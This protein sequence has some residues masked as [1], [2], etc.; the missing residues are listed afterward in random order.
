[1]PELNH[2]GRNMS[3]EVALKWETVRKTCSWFSAVPTPPLV[4]TLSFAV[5]GNLSCVLGILTD[6]TA[7]KEWT[8][9]VPL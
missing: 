9:A 7:R 5:G 4:P 2:H 1:M 8:K 6:G 3:C